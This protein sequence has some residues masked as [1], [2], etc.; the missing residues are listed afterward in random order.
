MRMKGNAS[1]R[2]T[3]RRTDRFRKASE[4]T[5]NRVFHLRESGA[6]FAAKILHESGCI[7]FGRSGQCR[8][9]PPALRT[10]LQARPVLYPD[11]HGYRR[12]TELHGGRGH[13]TGDGNGPQVWPEAGGG[14]SPAGVLGPGGGLHHRQ[15]E[16]GLHAQPGRDV[17]QADQ[18][19][20]FRGK[21]GTC[22]RPDCN[23]A[24]CVDLRTRREGVAGNGQ[25]SGEGSDGF[26]G[27]D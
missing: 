19:R 14:G 9:G 23:G 4:N 22:V 8:S 17:Q 16:T 13:R 26:S 10:G 20:M 11:R 24:L 25:R 27:S 6:N 18:V 5:P 3:M 15:G 2:N 7:D 12:R 21:G 1:W